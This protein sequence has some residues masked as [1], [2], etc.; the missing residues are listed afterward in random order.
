MGLGA[1]TVIL[2][3][4]LLIVRRRVSDDG[5]VLGLCRRVRYTLLVPVGPLAVRSFD[6]SRRLLFGDSFFV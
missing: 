3:S 2:I 6:R 1:S 4:S 5:L